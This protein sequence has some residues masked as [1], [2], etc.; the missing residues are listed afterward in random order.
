MPTALIF[1]RNTASAL[2]PSVSLLENAGKVAL[3]FFAKDVRD[4]DRVSP[5][6]EA[7]FLNEYCCNAPKDADV[8][9]ARFC[10]LTK[11]LVRLTEQPAFLQRELNALNILDTFAGTR[12]AG[13]TFIQNLNLSSA[14]SWT[15]SA[16]ALLRR[17]W[18]MRPVDR[19]MVGFSR[20]MDRILV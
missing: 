2:E 15:F 10:L 18:P 5:E 3:T 13:A 11:R 4:D 14:L 8:V 12:V 9:I 1:G 6:R 19:T 17:R 20:P 16:K 7:H